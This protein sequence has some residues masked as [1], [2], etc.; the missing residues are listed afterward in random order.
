MII[1][2]VFYPIRM[3]DNTLLDAYNSLFFT[4]CFLAPHTSRLLSIKS[5]NCVQYWFIE[6]EHYNA[7]PF[8][9]NACVKYVTHLKKYDHIT[10]DDVLHKKNNIVEL[11]ASHPYTFR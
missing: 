11:L 2:I 9:L 10:N 6:P 4:S 1:E 5:P 7:E 3:N 8:E